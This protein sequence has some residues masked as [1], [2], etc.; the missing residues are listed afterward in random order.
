MEWWYRHQFIFIRSYSNT[1]RLEMR[2]SYNSTY[3]SWYWRLFFTRILI[4]LGSYFCVCGI[5]WTL[6]YHT[7]IWL[8]IR[9]LKP[10]NIS[11]MVWFISLT[12]YAPVLFITIVNAI[13]RLSSTD[14]MWDRTIIVKI[15]IIS[16]TK[17]T[18]TTTIYYS[19]S[20]A[21]SYTS[22]DN[23]NWNPTPGKCKL[24]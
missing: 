13:M 9:A 1:S 7:L 21:I 6:F 10:I 22:P 19:T 5:H 12:Y 23:P 15:I 18:H 4:I 8:L 14:R 20:P 2:D 11:N 17:V 24:G 16:M 3:W